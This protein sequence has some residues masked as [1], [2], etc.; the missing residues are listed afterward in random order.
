MPR[1]QRPAKP[2]VHS[3]PSTHATERAAKPAKKDRTPAAEPAAPKA[4]PRDIWDALASGGSG[5]T[6]RPAR[7]PDGTPVDMSAQQRNSLKNCEAVVTALSA[8]LGANQGRLPEDLQGIGPKDV[9]VKWGGDFPYVAV[10]Q[11]GK[12][13]FDRHFQIADL[14]KVLP[15]GLRNVPMGD[16]SPF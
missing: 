1:V 10:F 3:T 5:N 9:K 2:S 6:T 16:L 14:R 4:E 7:K 12:E 8:W 11:N 13:L 15:Q